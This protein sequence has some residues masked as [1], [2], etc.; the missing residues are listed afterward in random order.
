MKTKPV[1]ILVGAAQYTQRKDANPALD[2]LGL[3]VKASLHAFRDAGSDGL[4]AVIDTVCVINSFSRDDECLPLAVSGAL[5]I[6]PENVIY[7]LIGGNSPQTLV[8]RLARDI[9]AG[10]RR[11]VLLTGAEAIYSMYKASKGKTVLD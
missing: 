4:K 10:R 1:P 2:P 8:N 9:A 11:A 3:M 7:S 6:K 5:G